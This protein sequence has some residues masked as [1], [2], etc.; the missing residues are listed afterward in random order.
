MSEPYLVI[1]HPPEIKHKIQDRLERAYR[2]SPYAGPFLKQLHYGDDVVFARPDPNYIKNSTVVAYHDPGHIFVHAHCA[3]E[4]ALHELR[5][6]FQC[7]ALGKEKWQRLE[8]GPDPRLRFLATIVIESD[9]HTFEAIA[10]DH[11]LLPEQCFEDRLTAYRPIAEKKL[12]R[13]FGI[14]A[15]KLHYQ[16]PCADEI[17]FL[18][19]IA[20]KNCILPDGSN[21]F[22]AG[23][24]QRAQMKK[25]TSFRYR[26]LMRPVQ[27]Y[28]ER[29]VAQSNG[30]KANAPVYA[31][32]YVFSQK[33]KFTP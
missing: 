8:K 3:P 13:D 2:D 19:E 5:H 18:H 7:R 30:Q 12:F 22:F 15:H 27:E 10:D 9:A 14:A 21:Y 26:T 11:C 32:P 23:L 24:S 33:R 20:E 1:E 28:W 25:I 29:Q 6:E 4:D 17:S 31:G 16:T